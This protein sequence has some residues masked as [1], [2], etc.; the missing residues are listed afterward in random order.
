MNQTTP[1][2]APVRVNPVLRHPD[3]QR[4]SLDGPWRFKLDPDD[5]G[6]AQQWF[7]RPEILSETIQVPGCWQGQG[8]GH[9]GHDEVWDFRIQA[10]VFRAT[11]RG[12]G[13]Y[14]KE[15]TVPDAW[16][17]RRVWL[18]FGGAHP[19]AAAWLNGVLLGEN[20]LPFVPFGFEVTPLIKCGARNELVVRVHER[21]RLLG[22]AYNWQGNW[23]GL[24][25]GVELTATGESFL[26]SL[27][28]YPDADAK[29]LRIKVRV[30]G[31]PPA[32]RS[33]VLRVAV[34][35]AAGTSAPITAEFP[36]AE[37]SATFDVPVPAPRLWC[38]ET[39]HLYRV[40]A[41]LCSGQTVL[42]AQAERT[43]FVKLATAGNQFLI[44]DEP[45]FIRGSGD[46]VSCPETGCP[47]TDRDRWRRKLQVFRDYGYNQVRCQSYVY[48]PE[49][50]DVADEVGLLVQSE[51]GML[52]AWGS[53]TQWHVYAWPP[54]TPDHYPLLKRQWDL[55]VARDVN[56]PSA[57]IYCMSNELAAQGQRTMFPRIA[58]RCYRDTKAI[59]PTALVIWTDGGFNPDLPGDFVNE[60]VT[61]IEGDLPANPKMAEACRDRAVIEH[62]F[63]WWSSF[64]DVRI[65][66]KYSGAIRPYAA[67]IARATARQRGQEHLL[68]TYAA[69]SQCLQLLE[70]KAKLEMC[71]RD[72]PWL[73]GYSQFNAM[74]AN[75]SPQGVLDEFYEPKLADAARWRQTNGD[76]VV[77]S[78]L[79]FADR[80]LTTGQTFRC[81]LSVSDFSHP[82]FRAPRLSWRM[83]AGQ[84]LLGSGELSWTHTPYTTCPAGEVVGTV[85][86]VAEP[87]AARL[88][89]TLR[90]GDRVVTNSWQLW[91]FPTPPTRPAAVVVYGKPEFTWLQS[92]DLPQAVNGNLNS[93]T[94]VLTERLDDQLLGFLQAGGTVLLAAAEG[95]VRPH[96]PNFGF[97]KYFFAPPANYGPYEDGQNGTVIRDHP[98]LGQ[99][100]HEGFADLQFYRMIDAAPPLDL[101]PFGLNDEDP[102]IRVIHRYPVCHPL[103]YLLERR[104]G[105]GRLI[106]SALDLDP[107]WSEARYLLGAIA[108]YAAGHRRAACPVLTDAARQRITELTTGL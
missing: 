83:V 37:M 14:G 8:F 51:M 102:V 75:P 62:E 81:P 76:T 53:N 96:P 79:G 71:R 95:L 20:D 108:A 28:L 25:R 103:G 2:I 6:L 86:A 74:D 56:H 93:S 27:R 21:H 50:F 58:W 70:M 3:E 24:Y 107:A 55:V 105:Q 39:P 85:P 69:N 16:H 4:V 80:V 43:G 101:E 13:W 42:D 84:K 63:R 34:A 54:P 73:A 15:F 60:H 35:P 57:N 26:E 89:A 18:N 41:K 11:Y 1:P 29:Q 47:D 94:V 23:S 45:Y 77:L 7:A 9:D 82:P 19:S 104:S 97:V 52:G 88:D 65:A 98:M 92:W 61:A 106:L 12:T 49:Y 30:G 40:E 5:A 10:R 67:A 17:G 99:F 87:T 66:A 59:K 22:L 31:A 33:L 44:N 78:G 46:F 32:A 100:P 90:E 48:A 68:E 64:P 36:L 72:Y 38:P 91:L